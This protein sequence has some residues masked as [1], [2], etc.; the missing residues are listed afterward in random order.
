MISKNIAISLVKIIC[1]EKKSL[2]SIYCDFK[3]IFSIEDRV[4]LGILLSLS[5]IDGFLQYSEQ[6]SCI[7]ILW[8]ESIDNLNDI[9]PNLEPKNEVIACLINYIQNHKSIEFISGLTTREILMSSHRFDISELNNE[10]ARIP[11]LL[12]C[13]TSDEITHQYE[14]ALVEIFASDHFWKSYEPPLLLIEPELFTITNNEISNTLVSS[15]NP[16]FLF[17][18]SPCSMIYEPP[19]SIIERSISEI[20]KK[21]EVS[22]I[23]SHLENDPLSLMRTLDTQEKISSFMTINTGS[24][25]KIFIYLAD[26]DQEIFNVFVSLPITRHIAAVIVGVI[27]NG[28][29]PPNFVE[30]LAINTIERIKSI[31]NEN[32]LSKSISSFCEMMCVLHNEQVIFSDILLNDLH[33]FCQE[34]TTTSLPEFI[35]LSSIVN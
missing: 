32:E 35:E 24:A 31:K 5:L 25:R 14:D 6:I 30:S 27:L 8:N 17:D 20:L 3:D 18:D 13:E 29:F 16:P 19:L 12:Y 26:K 10:R 23:I 28:I 7:W 11:C 15:D 2:E 1:S 9:L 34:C 21:R 33:D 4:V 22:I